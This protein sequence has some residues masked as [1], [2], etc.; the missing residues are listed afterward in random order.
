MASCAHADLP[1][2]PPPRTKIVGSVR[3]LGACHRGSGQVTR[4]PRGERASHCRLVPS[5]SR[6]GGW[7]SPPISN[8]SARGILGLYDHLRFAEPEGFTYPGHKTTEVW[9]QPRLDGTIELSARTNP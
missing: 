8:S 2:V 5:P 3:Y 1:A 7:P 6:P 9:V 4:R